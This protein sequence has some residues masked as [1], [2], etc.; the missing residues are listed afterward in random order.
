M[1]TV[2]IVVGVVAFLAIDG[3]VLYM[4]LASRRHA[5]QYGSIPVP[6][7]STITLPAGKLKLSYQES[8]KAG[9]TED[10]IDF[11]VPEA[12]EVTVESS[13]G[14]SLAIKG[15]GFKGM[16]SSLDT[17]SNWSRALIGTVKVAQPGLYEVTARG[18]LQDAIEPQVLIG[19]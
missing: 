6:G 4:V 12:L 15:P 10:S 16:G 18:E 3:V 14:E 13:S 9:G 1:T 5:G 2:I 17:G 8:Y 7:E 11:G 19:R